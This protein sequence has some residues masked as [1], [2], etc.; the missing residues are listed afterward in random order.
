MFTR[1]SQ[2]GREKRSIFTAEGR[3]TG[4][5]TLVVEAGKAETDINVGFV[6][7][8]VIEG[9]AFL[10]SDYDGLF[11]PGD[12]ALAQVKIELTKIATGEVIASAVTGDDGRFTFGALRGANYRLRAVLPDE[13]VAFTQTVAEN[14]QGNWFEA[15]SGRRDSTLNTLALSDMEH[16]TLWVGAVRTGTLSGQIYFDDNYSGVRD[17]QEAYASGLAVTLMNEGGEVLARARTNAQGAYTFEGLT[18]GSY[19]VGLAAKNGYVFTKAG[20][21]NHFTSVSDEGEGVSEV[22]ALAMGENLAGIDG[23][24]IRPGRISG[25]I[26]SDDNDNGLQDG[27]EGG[28]SGVVVTLVNAQDGTEAFR[29]VTEASG[30]YSFNRVM[31]GTYYVHYT[32]PEGAAF[33]NPVSGGSAL[34]GEGLQAASDIFRFKTAE[35]REMPLGGGVRLA[36]LAGTVFEDLNGS[37]AQEAGEPPLAGARIRVGNQEAV[38][39]ADG[40]F[41]L[42][43]IRPAAYTLEIACPAGYVFSRGG[44]ALAPR[45]ELAVTVPYEAAAGQQD[46]A[47]RIGMVRPG[48]VAGH[49]WMDE[50]L[51]AA[52]EENESTLAGMEVILRDLTD[53]ETAYTAATDGEG[54]FLF[55]NLVPGSYEATL[56]IPA[57]CI[58]AGRG[59]ATFQDNGQGQLVQPPFNLAAGET[60][61]DLLAGVIQYTTLEGMAWQDQGGRQLPLEG[62]TITLAGDGGAAASAVTGADGLYSFSQVLPGSYILEVQLPPGY[63]LVNRQDERVTSGRMRSVIETEAGGQGAS[64]PFQVVMAANESGLDIGAVKPGMLGD[65]AWLDENGNGLWD[66]GEAAMPGIT[67]SLLKNGETVKET[68]TDVYGYYLF[69]DIYPST[70]DVRVTWHEELTPTR[71]RE[72][73][74]L[75]NSELRESQETIQ[76]LEGIEI[77][78]DVKDFAFDFGFVL[79]TPGVYPAAMQTAPTQVWR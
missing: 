63:L 34:K 43:G 56:Q 61:A 13:T 71:Q 15:K 75:L 5:K 55:E 4:E 22:L 40:G 14:V 3:R 29:L 21:G 18:P 48:S 78:S 46:T 41:T 53:G 20:E 7:G 50:N 67:V 1:Y 51:S 8:G 9:V 73:F 68:V 39:G 12:P 59:Q 74:A 49:V 70:Y 35:S 47:R 33:A 37:G 28:L 26:F 72:D 54:R 69:S 32:L 31:P 42:A 27:E 45:G 57:A 65:M 66:T 2:T 44:D 38:T 79:R 76:L 23:G 10:D 6:T 17:G 77:R 19:R 25:Q 60:K 16:K 30:R 52:W 11:Q 64:A 36:A 24:L 58:A 62:V